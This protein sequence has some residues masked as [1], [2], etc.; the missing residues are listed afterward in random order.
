MMRADEGSLGVCLALD[1]IGREKLSTG[2]QKEE[3][4][5]EREKRNGSTEHNTGIKPRA[6]S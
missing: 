5:G 3:K 1:V 2:G 4:N 6:L